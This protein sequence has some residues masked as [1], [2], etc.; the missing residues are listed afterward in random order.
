M[1]NNTVTRVAKIVE[2]VRGAEEAERNRFIANIP[3]KG[4]FLEGDV[5]ITQ[6]QQD[7]LRRLTVRVKLNGFT[8]TYHTT[9]RHAML[10]EDPKQC[11][12][13][14]LRKVSDQILMDILNLNEDLFD[15]L[16]EAVHGH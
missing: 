1:F 12:T 14:T 7:M 10:H 3:L 13:D 5:S 8:Y 16:R 4:N 15:A 9:V 6:P 11:L 2:M